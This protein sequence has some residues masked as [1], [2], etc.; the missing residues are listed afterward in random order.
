MTQPATMAMPRPAQVD[1]RHLP[2]EQAEQQHQRD[3]VDHRRGDQEREGHAQRHA[4]RH[5]ADEQRHRRA[6]AERRDDAQAG[7]QHIADAF[8]LAGEDRRVRSGVKKER[9]MPTPKTTSVSSISTLGVSK[10][11]NSTASSRWLA[12][13]M[14]KR[15]ATHSENE[16][17]WP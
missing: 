9:T 8:P 1:H 6:G 4:R 12:R 2:A 7:R 15:V 5:K 16:A 17:S 10:T 11:K 13:S 14:G 3:L